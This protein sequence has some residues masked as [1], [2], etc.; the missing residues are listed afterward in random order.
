MIKTSD[1]IQA[2]VADAQPVRRLRPPVVRAALWL[3]LPALVF[4]LLAL[5]HGVRPDFA[6]RLAQPEFVVGTA[7]SLLTGVL[8][9]VG[10]FML[11]LPDR[12]RT[13]AWLPV[14]TLAV[15]LVTLGHGCLTNWV[16]IGAD[17]VQLG[18]TARCF[19]TVLMT[20]LPLS[21]AMFGM[22]RHGSLLRASTVAVTGSL[23]VAA[24]SATAMS[25]FHRLDATVM[26][27]VWNL[28]TAALIVALG[29][30]LARRVV[31]AGP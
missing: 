19:A 22:L 30:W 4:G 14:P 6:Q 17:G 27:L 7:A 12:S 11:N 10:S 5:G 28:G 24:M 8:A 13:W 3:L 2:L 1:L 20:S 29:S 23:A 18:E 16:A 26:I 21:L 9:A 31:T 15:W 25:I